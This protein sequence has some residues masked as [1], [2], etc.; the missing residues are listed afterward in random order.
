MFSTKLSTIVVLLILFVS[1]CAHIPQESVQLNQVVG[2]G[3]ADQNRAYINLLN[4]YFANKKK[5]I[6]DFIIAT[7]AP[8]L[9]ANIRSK[10]KA[11]GDSI[12]PDSISLKIVKIII[13][14]RDSMQ[15]SLDRVK[16]E[17]LTTAQENSMLLSNAN[18]GVTAI[19]QSAISVDKATKTA[20]HSIDSLSGSKFKLSEF[21]STFDKYL[22]D[23][24]NG[25]AKANDLYDKANQILKGGN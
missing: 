21:E 6:D 16:V 18:S 14:K 15:L 2:K 1:D 20:L 7:Y 10:V 5:A 12:I 24:G 13:A 8:A 19:L 11:A 23:M 25:S 17:I 4:D 22:I 3:I 9:M